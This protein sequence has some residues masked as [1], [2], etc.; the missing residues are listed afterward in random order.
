MVNVSICALTSADVV[1]NFIFQLEYP[2]I[3]DVI[4]NNG[5]YYHRKFLKICDAKCTLTKF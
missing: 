1:A 4:A 2:A 5:G 3:Q